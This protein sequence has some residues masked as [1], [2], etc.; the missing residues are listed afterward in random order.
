MGDS[1]VDG[2]VHGIVGFVGGGFGGWGEHNSK[3]YSI[4]FFFLFSYVILT[5]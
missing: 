4:F 3:F 1:G 5:T 2:F